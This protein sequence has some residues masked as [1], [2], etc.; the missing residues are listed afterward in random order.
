[1]EGLPAEEYTFGRL[2]QI[3]VDGKIRAINIPF[4]PAYPEVHPKLHKRR[5]DDLAN[6]AR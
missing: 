2:N 3:F 5:D 4:L 6:D 1:M